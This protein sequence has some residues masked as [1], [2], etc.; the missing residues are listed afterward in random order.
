[1]STPNG[2]PTSSNP[3]ENSSAQGRTTPPANHQDE[4]ARSA[5]VLP[6]TPPEQED[7]DSGS[8]A[9]RPPAPPAPESHAAESNAAESNAAESNAAESHAPESNAAE[10]HAPEQR[11]QDPQTGEHQS[12]SQRPPIAPPPHEG[13]Q[14]G[15]ASYGG[16]QQDPRGAVAE[17][18]QNKLSMFLKVS[19][20]LLSAVSLASISLL[21][22]GD[23]EGRFER[24]FSTFVLFAIFVLFTAFDTRR[25]Q[26]SEWYAPVALI[27]NAYIL[28]LLLIVI[29]MTPYHPFTLGWEIFWKSLLV[30][31]VTR[32]VILCCQLLLRLGEHLPALVTRFAFSTSVLAVLSGILFTAPV[33]IESFDVNVP[34]LYW[35]IATAT[36]ILTALGLAITLLLRWYYSADIRAAR[37]ARAEAERRLNAASATQVQNQPLP[38]APQQ[39]QHPQHQQQAP[40]QVQ[41][42]PQ[43][44][45]PPQ[46]LLPWPTFADGRPLPAGPDGQPDFSVLQR[47]GQ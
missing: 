33:G 24:V 37:K 36:L 42:A 25:E 7:R 8:P 32:A 14:Q 45:A 34:D 17:A 23:F 38:H 1:M 13:Q 5:V 4:P 18:P 28:G 3:A 10:S 22:I 39:N 27:A 2:K 11:V 43:E 9:P 31:V 21:F 16:S 19:I 6:P 35:K 20:I 29:W 46:Q 41:H 30:I 47:P 40:Q 12:G 15:S 44:Q 26:K